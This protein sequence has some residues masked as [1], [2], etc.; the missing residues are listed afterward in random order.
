MRSSVDRGGGR[1]GGGG[2]R[3]GAESD[4][5]I[6]NDN[7]DVTETAILLD[8]ATS[9]SLCARARARFIFL[10][11]FFLF[12]GSFNDRGTRTEHPSSATFAKF[13]MSRN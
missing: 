4:S 1:G 11:P 2:G 13:R 3:E 5:V 8:G 9:N 12:N 6:F 10:F 7:G